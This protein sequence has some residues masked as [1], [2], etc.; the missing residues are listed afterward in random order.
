MQ[1]RGMIKW[2]P[3]NSVI[4]SKYLVF[5]IEKEKN[6]I[7]KPTLSEEQLEVIENN[8]LES[9]INQTPL[10]FKIYQGGFIKELKGIVI[11]VDT[12]KKSILLDN[13]KNLY[14]R[15]II[16]ALNCSIC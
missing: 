4:N 3:F 11:K 15:E 13:H 12:V 1:D 5:E 6:K 16:G 8:I 9:L 7:V 2:A 14:F 10:L